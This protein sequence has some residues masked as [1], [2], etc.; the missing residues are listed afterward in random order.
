[1]FE[2]TLEQ[3]YR[4]ATL[5]VTLAAAGV[6]VGLFYWRAFGMLRRRQWLTLL[7]L[8]IAAIVVL[9][10]LLF[11]P[12]ISYEKNL[13][14]RP[15]VVFAVD[16]SASMSIADDATGVTRFNQARSKIQEW[17][18]ALA[19]SFDVR[20]IDFAEQAHAVEDAAELTAVTPDGK[21]TSISR[22]LVGAVKLVP[23]KGIE[24]VVLLSDGNH[25]AAKDPRELAGKL[26]IVIHTVGVGASLRSDASCHDVQ[27]AAIS[28]GE[29][30]LLDNKAKL[31]AS[32]EGVGLAGRVI[33][34]ALEE[35][36]TQ[37]AEQQV[38]LDDAP[39]PQQVEFE[40]TP[41]RKGRR[42][43]TVRAAVLPEERFRENNARSTTAMVVEPGL[44]VL[45]LEGTL[46]PE[47]GALVDRFLAKDPDLQFCSLVQTRPNVFLKRS[48]IDGL[49]IGTIP[50][51]AETFR[52]FDV[53]ILGDL[54]SSYLPAGRQELIAQR[55]RDGAGLVML[56]GY[57]SLGPGGYDG[58]PLGEILPVG[59]GDRKIGQVTEEFLPVLTPE[60]VRHPIFAN[61]ADFFPTKSGPAKE[62]GLP[63]LDGATRVQGARPGAT[64]L[65]TC[66]AAGD[67][68]VLAV[69]PVDKG[70]TAVFAGDT[71]RKW[72]Q[73]P[74][75][76][77][78]QSPYLRFW[79]QLVRYLAGRSAA[80]DATAGISG[81]TDKG[82]YE[83]EEPVRIAAIVRDERG[84]GTDKATVEATIRTDQKKPE[85]IALKG[86][87][88]LRGH[89]EGTFEPKGAGTYE[90]TLGAQLGKTTLTSEKLVVE[91]GR[92]NLEFEKLDLDE[93]LLA[94]IA[95]DSGGR[96]VHI[97]TADALIQQLDRTQRRQRVYLQQ[98]LYWPPAFWTIFVAVLTT[99]WIL[100]RRF[101]LR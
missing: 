19:G 23:P 1:M 98:P 78:Q 32:V 88:G 29:R 14:Q 71:T 77:D 59:L 70:Q 36:G 73:G 82:H 8:R 43:Y 22:A 72:Q 97:T 18:S 50:A 21:A 74:R 56:G 42:T 28:C 54:D 85:T 9:V 55:V 31:Q 11:R 10:L 99:E 25:N 60:G 41:T 79:G 90:M 52:K 92:A 27:I 3:G 86:V 45:Y 87:P 63:P 7:T 2:L 80:V 39:G 49:E 44:R 33:R 66:A 5:V 91:V 65:A 53:I 46:R 37:L 38:T 67:M 101:Q 20:V 57:H 58:T 30:L 89:Y 76:L 75:A 95:A 6:L 40:F 81:S 96:Y 15:A 69:Q 48:N 62:P 24:A 35:D 68:P 64:V 4:A 12:V 16:G 83:L 100:R 94:G 17:S 61:I 34:L 13:Q 26:G 51:D 84:E 47:Y 93:S